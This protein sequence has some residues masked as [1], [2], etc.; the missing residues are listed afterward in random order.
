LV[1]LLFTT[2]LTLVILGLAVTLLARTLNTK[3]REDTQ[4]AVLSDTSLGLGRISQEITNAGFGLKNNGIV[5]PDSGEG[6]IRVRANLNGLLRETT[7]GTVS[8]KDEDLAFSLV[9]N[10][11][12]GAS[13]VR[14]DIGLGTSSIVATLIDDTDVDGDG[15]GDGLTFTY[16]DATGAVVAPNLATR[17]GIALRVRLPQVG[18]PRAPGY[19][20]AITKVLTSSVVLRNS[21]LVLY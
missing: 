9:A 18:S 8:D 13:L 7:S 20:P 12:G 5:G 2:T 4:A 17:V 11:G 3:S 19:Q 1:E 21:N 16:F 15:D 14:T 10:P 6:T